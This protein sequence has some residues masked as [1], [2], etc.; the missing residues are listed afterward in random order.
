MERVMTAQVNW[1]QKINPLIK[2]VDVAALFIVYLAV[3]NLNVMIWSSLL[4][5]IIYWLHQSISVKLSFWLIIL[6]LITSIFSMTAMTF[7]GKGTHFLFQFGLIQI[8]TESLARGLML[9]LRSFTFGMLSLIFATTTE[10]VPFFYSLMQ[11]GRL[12]IR[13]AY[14]CLA[15]FR[16]LP[17][18]AEEFHTLQQAMKIRGLSRARGIRAVYAR[19]TRYC[20]TMLV[21]SIRR[22]QRTA[23]AMEAKRFSMTAARTYYYRIGWGRLDV[24]FAVLIV[25]TVALS[26]VLAR[27]FPITPFTNVLDQY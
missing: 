9:G 25:L 17:M 18:M 19:F 16:M 22:A 20:L 27:L 15:A 10:P 8:S 13:I 12:P 7:F 2:L 6:T 23:V 21:Q 1:L 5:F 11:Q 4:F 26:F 14:G 24:A 3:H